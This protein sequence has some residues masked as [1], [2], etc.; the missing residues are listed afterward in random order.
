MMTAVQE[1][2]S[3]GFLFYPMEMLTAVLVF[4]LP[5]EKRRRPVLRVV[6]F[7]ACVCLFY[8]LAFL[9]AAYRN[10]Q[11]FGLLQ[12]QSSTQGGYLST[13][14]W[15]GL[16]FVLL[17]PMILGVCR[18]PLREAAYCAACAYLME[19]IAYCLRLLE[20]WALA[21]VD[22]SVGSPLYF[23][24]SILVYG[25]VYLLFVRKMV[26]KGHYVTS[27]LNSLSLTLGVLAVVL[28]MS[29]L[30]SAYEFEVV[31]AVYA[32]F[33]CTGALYGQLR[34]QQKQGLEQ[35]LAL[36]Q[37]LWQQQKAQYEMSR[38]TIQLINQKCHDLKHQVE[39]LRHIN[40]PEYRNTVIDS[41]QDAVMIYD[42]KIETGNEILNTVL[43]E[44][45]LRCQQEHITLICLAE[46]SA[47]TFLDTVD[48]YTLFGNALDN[49]MEAVA[50]LDEESRLIRVTVRRRSDLVLVQV[51]NPYQG[52]LPLKDGLP[53]TGKGDRNWH[54]FGLRSIQSIAERYHGIFQI[55]GENQVFRLRLTFPLEGQSAAE[56]RQS[57]AKATTFEK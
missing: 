1:H 38:D 3:S 26:Q 24:N 10:E 2:F 55:S 23:L 57:A 40:E 11:E 25:V 43:T 47:L 12:E 19:H 50:A 34:Q 7:A 13:L 18:V 15:C 46:G 32:L 17:I 48:L 41:L 44:K 14:F 52:E 31:H 4:I 42:T 45:S 21:P 30:A 8:Q 16:L 35:E 56:N 36:Q 51:E 5:L 20:G 54:G 39:A 6:G 22:V 28:V 27:A 37:Q 9:V 49:A 29:A 53:E 33:C